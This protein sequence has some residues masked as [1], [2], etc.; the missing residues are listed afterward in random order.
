MDT[1][2]LEGHKTP[3]AIAA[4]VKMIRTQRNSSF[5]IV[6]GRDDWRF[7][8]S[9]K[10]AGCE[11]VNGEGKPNVVGGI[12]HLDLAN[13]RGALGVVDGDHDALMGAKLPSRNLVATDAHDLEA[14][15]CRSTAL[16]LVLGEYGATNKVRRFEA[17]SKQSV[18]TALLERTLVFGRLRWAVLRLG[19]NID[20]NLLRVPRFV[21]EN[22]WSV[23]GNKL[24]NALASKNDANKLKHDIR[25][26]PHID[27][28]RVARGHD[29]VEILR[30]GL[31]KVLGDIPASIGPKDIARSLRLAMSLDELKKTRFGGDIRDWELRNAPYAVFQSENPTA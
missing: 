10:N 18:R 16:D 28:W 27:P 6:E 4:E 2:M 9:R 8:V 31:K 3:G 5:L 29:M 30:I 15:L 26:L 11:L 21:E 14:L 20:Y 17:R 23:D 19:I 25:T 24:L 22:D 12:A 13:I 7:W 1:S